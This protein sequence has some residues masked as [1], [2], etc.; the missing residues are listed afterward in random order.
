LR[1][2]EV[3]GLS[4]SRCGTGAPLKPVGALDDEIGTLAGNFRSVAGEGA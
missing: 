4:R 3:A 1:A 2:A